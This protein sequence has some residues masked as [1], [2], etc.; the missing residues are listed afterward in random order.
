LR[1]S[2]F[3][4]I[5]ID[6]VAPTAEQLW[7]TAGYGHFT[8]MQVRGGKTRGLDLHLA[9]LSSS[10]K[11]LSG[12]S[13]DDDAVRRLMRHALAS[14]AD[15]SLRVYVFH[16]D[17]GTSVMVTINPP[18]PPPASPQRL[19]SVDSIRPVAHVKHA[20]GF[21]QQ[22]FG[23]LAR[24]QGYDDA[25]FT[26]PDGLV[27]EAMIANIGFFAGGEVVWPDAPVLSGITMQLLDRHLP[28][29]GVTT[30]RARVP[31]GELSVYDG[32]FVSNSRGLAAVSQIDQTPLPPAGELM[33]TLVRVYESVPWDEI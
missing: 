2:R 29:H 12:T 30:R 18:G 1:V 27:A 10:A 4:R 15:A 25:L 19:L 23:R 5:E 7:Q 24:E 26:T 17:P 14:D 32:A 13:L 16:A 20:S 33:T 21:A 8:A 6:G 31:L 9:R 28:A 22:H 11:E 3:S